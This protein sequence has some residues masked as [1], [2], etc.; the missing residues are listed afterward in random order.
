MQGSNNVYKY[1]NAL[2]TILVCGMCLCTQAADFAGGTGEPDDPYQI[3]TAEQLIGLGEDPN[4]YDQCFVLTADIDLD[5]N[6][7]GRKVFTQAVI[8]PATG[9]PSGIRTSNG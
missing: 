1:F 9:N 5:P 2:F 3:A 6:L 4:L 8:A 7:P